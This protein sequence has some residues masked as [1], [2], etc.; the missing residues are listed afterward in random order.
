MLPCLCLFWPCTCEPPAEPEPRP[1]LLERPGLART[2]PELDAAAD[3]RRAV[4]E[5]ARGRR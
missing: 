1:W 4:R 3:R 5:L 2:R